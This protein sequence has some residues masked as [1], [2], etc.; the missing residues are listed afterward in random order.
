MSMILLLFICS[1]ATE[2]V[3]GAGSKEE[4]AIWWNHS[5]CVHF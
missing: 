3:E 4:S 2:E 5:S 1:N